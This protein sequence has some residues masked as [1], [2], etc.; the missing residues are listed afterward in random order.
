MAA[1]SLFDM[2][3]QF[4]KV[5]KIELNVYKNT[6]NTALTTIYIRVAS[7]GT[8]YVAANVGSTERLL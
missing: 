1:Q 6:A 4:N 7:E 5:A 2:C 8:D 3:V